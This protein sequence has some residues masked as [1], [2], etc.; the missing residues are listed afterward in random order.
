MANAEKRILIIETDLDL[1]YF[2]QQAFSS[3]GFR[4]D[5]VDRGA[6]G[7]K[8]LLTEEFHLALINLEMPEISGA[9]ICRA[10]RKHE[11]TR[12]LPLVM[13]ANKPFDQE[14]ADQEKKTCDA[15]DFLFKPITGVALE[16][17]LERVFKQRPEPMEKKEQPIGDFTVPILLHRFYMEKATGLLHLHHGSAK[18]VVYF[19][20]GYP[21]F[22][23]SNV[24]NECLGRM[25]V[26]EGRITQVDCDQSVELS[27][28][29]GR[30]QGT[31]LIGMGLLT[32]QDLHNALMHQVTEKLLS[33]FAWRSGT[34]QFVSGKGFKRNV[35]RI[36][37]TPATLIAKGIERFWASVQL[38]DYLAPFRSDYLKQSEDPQYRFQDVELTKRGQAILQSCRGTK[39]LEQLLDDHPLARREVQKIISALLI[40]ELV[41]RHTLPQQ[42]SHEDFPAGA[43]DKVVDSKLRYK[44]L[45]DYQRIVGSNYFSALGIAENG[46]SAEARRAYYR[47]AKEYHPDR[48]LGGDLTREMHTKINEIFQYITQAYTVL[49]DADSR[50]KYVEE[51]HHGPVKKLD[52]NQVIEAEGA[53]QEGRALIKI[54]HYAGAVK[55]L[56]RAIELSPEEPEYMSSYAWALFKTDPDNRANLNQS[57]EI[58][59][60]ARELNAQNDQT[61]LYLGHVYKTL[62]KE[63]QAERSFEMAVQANPDCTEALREL[64]LLNLRR[65][66]APQSKGLFS[67]FMKKS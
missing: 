49:I 7:L 12:H 67:K 44:I 13:I 5:S 30:L 11:Q 2:L 56:K 19:K 50:A 29:S 6:E 37:L 20:D 16:K 43:D 63:R 62:G 10:L 35:T 8:L 28:A 24:L 33:T 54:R 64:R 40:S 4:V 22:T 55:V 47:L 27:R 57:L 1:R 59:L 31:E 34:W 17:M 21:I 58:L 42:N 36:Q 26:K 65:E 41:E 3:A 25:L 14:T 52:I 18:K 15:D 53:Y 51:L 60:A 48:F 66:Q 23:R 46:S 38:D 39:T 32:P 45:D 9:N 61:L